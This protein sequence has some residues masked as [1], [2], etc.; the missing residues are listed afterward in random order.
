MEEIERLQ[1]D[2]RVPAMRF[3]RYAASRKDVR[4]VTVIVWPGGVTVIL[5]A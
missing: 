3:A 2:R 1:F 5:L 4:K